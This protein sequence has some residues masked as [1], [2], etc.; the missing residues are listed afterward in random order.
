MPSSLFDI[1]TTFPCMGIEKRRGSTTINLEEVLTSALNRQQAEDCSLAFP[2]IT[3]TAKQTSGDFDPVDRKVNFM[4]FEQSKTL[5][6]DVEIGTGPWRYL[7]V[8][9][10]RFAYLCEDGKYYRLYRWWMLLHILPRID[11]HIHF[12][13]IIW[14]SGVLSK[15]EHEPCPMDW[16]PAAVALEVL[17]RWRRVWRYC[18]W[19]WGL[20]FWIWSSRRGDNQQGFGRAPRPLRQN[21]FR[22]ARGKESRFFMGRRELWA[23]EA[24]FA[25]WTAMVQSLD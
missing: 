25:R 3:A 20:C 2:Y 19:Y 23:M 12:G 24:C 22:L 18:G 1:S 8:P 6:T 21:N 14:V 17:G 7:Q 10:W 5:L 13:F 15:L 11:H 16:V 9:I 4:N